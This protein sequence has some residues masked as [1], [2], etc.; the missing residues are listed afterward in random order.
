MADQIPEDRTIRQAADSDYR[1]TGMD[2]TDLDVGAT[3]QRINDAIP[4]VCADQ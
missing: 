4:E 1:Y 3:V 2:T